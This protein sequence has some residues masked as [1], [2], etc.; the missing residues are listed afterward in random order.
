MSGKATAAAP[1]TAAPGG[2]AAAA[3]AATAATAAE[4]TERLERV[5]QAAARAFESINHA[6]SCIPRGAKKQGTLFGKPPLERFACAY[7]KRAQLKS[8]TE[9]TNLKSSDVARNIFVLEHQ[10]ACQYEARVLWLR[11]VGTGSSNFV[12]VPGNAINQ[13][14]ASEKVAEAVRVW[15]AAGGPLPFQLPAQIFHVK[16]LKESKEDKTAPDGLFWSVTSGEYVLEATLFPVSP[17]FV[18]A[19]ALEEDPALGFYCMSW[20][21]IGLITALRDNVP[22]NEMRKPSGKQLAALFARLKCVRNRFH[23]KYGTEPLKCF[24]KY[25]TVIRQMANAKKAADASVIKSEAAAAAAAAADAAADTSASATTALHAPVC[26]SSYL[27]IRAANIARNA[28]VFAPLRQLIRDLTHTTSS[29]REQP[30]AGCRASKRLRC[31]AAAPLSRNS[32]P[33][34]VAPTCTCSGVGDCYRCL[35]CCWRELQKLRAIVD[36]H[37]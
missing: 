5:T 13:N 14:V 9:N 12:S 30:A 18:L 2:S 20:G 24:G 37:Q 23:T 10:L 7:T 8:G 32:V 26:Q 28:I 35:G 3:T 15:E 36:Q 19:R 17:P 16:T 33:R 25:A 21:C 11:A 6:A 31:D 34:T 27:V 22:G 1:T 29:E 4:D